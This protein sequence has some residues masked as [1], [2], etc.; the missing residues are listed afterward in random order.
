[1]SNRV[2]RHYELNAVDY[3]KRIGT[4][5]HKMMHYGDHT[6]YER[7]FLEK[8]LRY[9]TMTSGS[10]VKSSVVQRVESLVKKAEI[11][12]EDTVL[13][14]G[15]GR[16]GNSIWIAE[17]T[18]ADV[19]GLDINEEHLEE[20][21]QKAKEKGLSDRIEFVHGSFDD[22]SINDFDVYFAIESQCYSKDEEELVNQIY[23][24]LNPSGRV[25]ISDGFRTKRLDNSEEK[26]MDLMHKGWGV[27]YIAHKE[28][29]QNYMSQAGFRDIEVENIEE[30]IMPT[31]QFLHRFS[32]PTIPYAEALKSIFYLGTIVA[33]DKSDKNKKYKVKH[34]RYKQLR[35]LATTARHQ[36]LTMR[37]SL[38][39]QFDFYARKPAT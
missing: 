12:E 27:D 16:G 21:R 35:D 26:R 11:T 36:Y 17:N 2:R 7:T 3:E 13:D 34:E 5:E 37:D 24:A 14:A 33:R 39:T 6:N 4:G 25:I 19:I 29:F 20:A 31:S 28:D 32:L 1:M 9:L 8:F 22:L 18:G 15:C 38:W 10:E 23:E 30:K